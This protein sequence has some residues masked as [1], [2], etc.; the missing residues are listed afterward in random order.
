MLKFRTMALMLSATALVLTG[1]ANIPRG[2][3]RIN[4]ITLE[5][6][7]ANGCEKL[8]TAGS[9][10]LILINGRARNMAKIVQRALTVPGATHIALNKGDTAWTGARSTVFRCPNPNLKTSDPATREISLE[11][12]GH[13]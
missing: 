6:A 12:I 1:C 2:A 4:L 11:Y 3:D 7:R 9:M 5:E 8:D 10:S 13:D